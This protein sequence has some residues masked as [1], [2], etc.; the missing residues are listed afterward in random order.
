M[1]VSSTEVQVVAVFPFPGDPRCGIPSCLA[2]Q[3]ER[4]VLPDSQFARRP[5]VDNVRRFRH[6]E[7]SYLKSEFQICR[8]VLQVSSTDESSA[9]TLL[10][11]TDPATLIGRRQ[12]DFVIQ[13]RAMKLNK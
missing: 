4:F 13:S 5:L 3:L 7:V 12:F 10:L 11:E 1:F 6:V 2:C 8:L 9:R